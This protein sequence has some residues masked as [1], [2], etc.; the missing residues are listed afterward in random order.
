[1]DSPSDQPMNLVFDLKE[2]T[3]QNKAYRQAIV[4][5]K[6]SQLVLMSLKPGQE[7]GAETHQEDQFIYLLEG[8]G[9][10][11]LWLPDK[12]GKI[13]ENLY[14]LHQGI[15]LVIPAGTKHNILN[16]LTGKMKLFTIYTPPEHDEG[17]Y[18]EVKPK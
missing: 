5:T 2:S 4:T 6:Q 3:L 18:Q 10:A 17:T 8:F 12:E 9:V 14:D 1:M 15:G 7:I 16:N 13:S 11:I